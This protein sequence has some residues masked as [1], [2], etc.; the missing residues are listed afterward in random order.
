MAIDLQFTGDQTERLVAA[1]EAALY[2]Y[3]YATGYFQHAEELVAK[4][5]VKPLDDYE[6]EALLTVRQLRPIIE[7]IIGQGSYNIANLQ[8]IR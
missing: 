7:D 6:K 1:V 2:A 3:T 5:E 8:H 4:A